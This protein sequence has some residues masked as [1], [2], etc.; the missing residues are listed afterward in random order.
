MVI[1]FLILVSTDELANIP[2]VKYWLKKAL[3][4]IPIVEMK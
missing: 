2:N 1:A 4:G 3:L